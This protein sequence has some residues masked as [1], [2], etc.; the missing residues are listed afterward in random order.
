MTLRTGTRAWKVVTKDRKSVVP[1]LLMNEFAREISR[2]EKL[3][4]ID[5]LYD[6]KVFK[7]YHPNSIIRANKGLPPLTAFKSAEMAHRWK[8][9]FTCL[10]STIVIPIIG[11]KEEELLL[12]SFKW[13]I[14]SDTLLLKI[15]TFLRHSRIDGAIG[16]RKIKVIE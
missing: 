6:R 14:F 15:D 11:Y 9:C 10:R 12:S 4:L 2:K 8:N 5:K 13:A 16:F 1:M 7:T 3:K